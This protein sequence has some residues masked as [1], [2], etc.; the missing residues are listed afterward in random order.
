M[1]TVTR[2]SHWPSRRAT[3]LGALLGGG[4]LAVA[5]GSLALPGVP[6]V[7]PWAWVVFGREIVGPGPALSTV[8]PTGWKPLPVLFT[9]PLGLFDGAAP[10]LWLVVVR[11]AGLV[12]MVLGFRLGARAG[13][14]V[15]GALAALALLACSTWLRFLWAGNVEPLVVAL[16]LGAIE[17]HLRGRHDAAFALGALA[18]LGRPE[19]W[20]MVVGYAAYLWRVERRR[21]PLAVGM[22]TMLALWIVPDWLGSGDPLHALHGAQGSG[23]P[24]GIQRSAA[25]GYELLRRASGLAPLPVWLGAVA[26][27]VLGRRTRDRTVRA[28]AFVVAAWAVP[29]VLAT[30]LGY[31][32][33]PRY[34]VEPVA[35]CGVLAGIG[36]VALVRISGSRRGRAAVAAALI[37]VSTPYVLATGAALAYQASEAQFWTTQQSG[38]WAAVNRA[39]RQGEPIARLHPVVEPG[40][41]ANGLAWKLGMRVHDVRGAFT[42]AARIAFLEGDDRTVLAQLRRRHA[43]TTPVAAAGRWHV[44]LLRWRP[45]SAPPTGARSRVSS[46]AADVVHALAGDDDRPA[47]NGAPWWSAGSHE[48]DHPRERLELF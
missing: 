13:G 34:L 15:A 27:V 5:G 30:A 33:I 17:L 42:P 38:L 21:W 23:E 11:C 7:D 47:A 14:V 29:T 44:L 48:L 40:A 24:I 39:Q 41:M 3:R 4:C 8:S 45:R 12:A 10:S 2:A 18:G 20:L 22:P 6:S 26:A 46:P 43:T 31:P 35:A 16:L 32:A 37:A 36:F 25:P 1:F 19:V 28:L 9:A